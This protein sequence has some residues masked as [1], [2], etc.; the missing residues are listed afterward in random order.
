[1]T[2]KN[3]NTEDD[4]KLRVLAYQLTKNPEFSEEVE[5]YTDFYSD[6]LFVNDIANGVPK[7][8]NV[9]SCEPDQGHNILSF[10]WNGEYKGVVVYEVFLIKE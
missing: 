6:M 10:K 3:L 2:T 9:I 4:K 8:Q 7:Y 5:F 1:M